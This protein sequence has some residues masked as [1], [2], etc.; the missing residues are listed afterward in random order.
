MHIWL[1][2]DSESPL[3]HF[4]P[5]HFLVLRSSLEAELGS[6]P[7]ETWI[8]N[9]IYLHRSVPAYSNRH[10]NLVVPDYLFSGFRVPVT[11]HVFSVLQTI[12]KV[13]LQ[14]CA[15][16]AKSF[17]SYCE[18]EK[19]VS[20]A[21]SHG[22]SF[23]HS[24]L[25]VD[26]KLFE[27][28]ILCGADEYLIYY[29]CPLFNFYLLLSSLCLFMFT[30][31][32]C[33]YIDID[34]DICACVYVWIFDFFLLHLGFLCFHTWLFCVFLQPCVLMNNIQQ[35]RVLLEKMFESMGAKQV[36]CSI[37]PSHMSNLL[38]KRLHV[39]LNYKES[40]QQS[41]LCCVLC[42]FICVA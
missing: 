6:K 36:R 29:H 31:F 11:P 10:W 16:L 15:L 20:A 19:I 33:P 39:C 26:L 35:M 24:R 4:I 7:I 12:T 13:L 3:L 1:I 38:V 28:S 22:G 30:V 41:E 9:L 34:V 23:L 37:D 21:A 14:Y 8:F 5:E 27:R 32:S 42:W 17:P 25:L 40:N 18:K 2:E